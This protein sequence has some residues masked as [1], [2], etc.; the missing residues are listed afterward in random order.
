MT[1]GLDRLPAEC[2]S[3]TRSWVD[4]VDFRVGSDRYVVTYA[5]GWTATYLLGDTPGTF[6]RITYARTRT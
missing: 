4:I 1:R 2:R 3:F 6:S 5:D